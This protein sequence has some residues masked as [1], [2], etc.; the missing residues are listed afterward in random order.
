MS[1]LCRIKLHVSTIIITALLQ[2]GELTGRQTAVVSIVL[3]SNCI[4][5]LYSSHLLNFK[6]KNGRN[7][8]LQIDTCISPEN[9]FEMISKLSINPNLAG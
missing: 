6:L 9:H 3:S 1:R 2:S 5:S 7:K 4:H 8:C